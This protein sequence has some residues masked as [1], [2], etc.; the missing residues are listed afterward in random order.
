MVSKYLRANYSVYNIRFLAD[1]AVTANRNDK[2]GRFFS[3]AGIII[4]W[5]N[6]KREKGHIKCKSS[7]LKQSQ[8]Q[9]LNLLLSWRAMNYKRKE[10]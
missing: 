7:L 4:Y 6:Q 10:F 8:S 9:K 1:G 3:W 5:A 2:R